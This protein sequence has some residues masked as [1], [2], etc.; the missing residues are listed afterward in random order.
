MHL[1]RSKMLSIQRQADIVVPVVSV[2]EA[3]LHDMLHA[4]H[5]DKSQGSVQLHTKYHY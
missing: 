5:D 1:K 2:F 3:V 4:D